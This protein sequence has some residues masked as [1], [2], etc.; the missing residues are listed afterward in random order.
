MSTLGLLFLA[1]SPVEYFVK[2]VLKE[3]EFELKSKLINV[4]ITFTES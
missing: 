3:Y 1:L 2:P 4:D